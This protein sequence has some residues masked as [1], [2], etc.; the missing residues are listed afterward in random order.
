MAKMVKKNSPDKARKSE[1][2]PVADI[3]SASR[4]V[5]PHVAGGEA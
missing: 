3:S 2:H 5:E 1:Q 4:R